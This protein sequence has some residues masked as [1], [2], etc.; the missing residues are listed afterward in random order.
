M[1]LQTVICKGGFQHF[2]HSPYAAVSS[3][4]LP[5][6]SNAFLFQILCVPAPGNSVLLETLRN[7]S[8]GNVSE[9]R[10]PMWERPQ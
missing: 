1:I 7:K 8:H 3:G 6:S 4:Q 5:P 10:L 2:H 9:S